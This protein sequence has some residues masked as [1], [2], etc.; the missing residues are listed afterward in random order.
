MDFNDG[1]VFR[2]V[3]DPAAQLRQRQVY[4]HRAVTGVTGAPAVDTTF[5]SH[6]TRLAG[7][8]LLVWYQFVYQNAGTPEAQ[9][10][11]L[12]KT[13]G[14]LRPNEAVMLD[15]ETRGGVTNP[16]DFARRW[17][18]VVE[19]RLRCRAW[20]YVPGA[21]AAALPRSFTGDR[22]VMAPRY[23]GTASRGSPPAWPH[24]VHQYTDRGPFPGCA[25]SGDTSYTALTVAQ[26]LARSR[27][28]EV[29]MARMPGALWEPLAADWAAQGRITPRILCVH[30]MVG[31]L[32]GT[33][34]YF[35]KN[36]YGGTE[37]HFGTGH[38][39]TK[40][41]WQDTLY[42]ADANLDGNREVVSIENADYGPGFPKW[43]LNDGSQVPAFTDA[44]LDANADILEWGCK[45]HSIPAV[46]IPDTRP[47]RTGIGY[48]RQ[49]IDPWRLSGAVRWSSANG[50]VC[51]GD[52]RISQLVAEI[53]PEVQRR[54]A[55]IHPPPP[56][57]IVPDFD[58]KLYR[59]K[60]TGQKALAAPGVWYVLRN[61]DYVNLA[62]SR[63]LV[64]SGTVDP[65]RDV[66][67]NEFTWIQGV[68][69]SSEV[70]DTA[71]LSGLDALAKRLPSVTSTG[72]PGQV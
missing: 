52:R 12:C 25:Q 10:D 71:V 29:P 72:Q 63:G 37:S 66:A 68:Y 18:A 42:R 62:V 55:G 65:R 39:G 69:L 1:S 64:A 14:S 56:E 54:L 6:R 17:L 24:D 31:S 33:R 13:L 30:T 57:E 45:T 48:H 41:Q 3:T 59:N 7:M 67:T 32:D 15:I 61:D 50:K 34:A 58:F 28:R 60:D 38:D 49:G 26:L 5:A 46:L 20:I 27:P 36:G 47:G 53:I 2:V 70:N 22:I 11:Y 44:Q 9:A 43:D 19:S 16:Q 35:R 4:M 40:V 51:P 21:L 23:S 8:P